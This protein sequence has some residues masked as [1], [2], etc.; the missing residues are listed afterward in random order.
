[1]ATLIIV[2]ISTPAHTSACT[3]AKAFSP[4]FD[5]LSDRFFEYVSVY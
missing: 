3:L 1:M 5:R 2:F 4:S